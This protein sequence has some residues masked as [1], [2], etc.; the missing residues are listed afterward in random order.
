[1]SAKHNSSNSLFQV[2]CNIYR[3]Q[4]SSNN[5]TCGYGTIFDEKY[6]QF[7]IGT[8]LLFYGIIKFTLNKRKQTLYMYQ[9]IMKKTQLINYSLFNIIYY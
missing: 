5:Q 8:Y 7:I 2:G 9:L 4:V 6:E 3:G 1:M